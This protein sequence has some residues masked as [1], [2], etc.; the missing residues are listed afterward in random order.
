MFKAI[1][2]L[3]HRQIIVPF[4]QSHAPVREV[5]LGTSIGLFWSLTPLIGIQMYLGLITWLVLRIFGIRFY[6]PI[7]IAMIWITNPV[8][9]PF[10]YYVFYV[11]GAVAYNV[12]GWEMATMNFARILEVIER[13]SSLELYEGLRYWGSF[14]INDMGAPMF[15]G[16]FMIGIPSAIAGYPITKILLNGFRTRQ[17]EKERIT[18][19]EWEKKY[20][21][22][23]SDK[24][25]S[26]FNILKN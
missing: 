11:T 20:V 21:R 22:K 15:L 17:A 14:L 25:R 9:L 16:G 10:F 7:A 23:D 18:L 8:T 13:S 1:Y 2:K 26:I 6:M 3:L 24:D 12:L 19:E 5:C 4:Q